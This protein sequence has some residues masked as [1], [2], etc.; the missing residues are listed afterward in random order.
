MSSFFGTSPEPPWPPARAPASHDKAWHSPTSGVG[1]GSGATVP[2]G[3]RRRVVG[4]GVGLG[5]SWWV[6]PAREARTRGPGPSGRNWGSWGEEGSDRAPSSYAASR[7]AS[8]HI[9]EHLQHRGGLRQGSAPTIDCTER[10]A[11]VVS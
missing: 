3:G 11:P 10:T 2:V 5:R 6:H 9:A 4:S 7:S 8:T 1:P